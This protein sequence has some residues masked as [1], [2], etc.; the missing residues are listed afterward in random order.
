M[1]KTL[2]SKLIIRIIAVALAVLAVVGIAVPVMGSLGANASAAAFSA[3]T[4]MYINAD[5]YA[6]F[7]SG[8]TLYAYSY[9]ESGTYLGKSDITPEGELYTFT[10]LSGAATVEIIRE[11]TALMNNAPST[12]IAGTNR[13]VYFCNTSG[14][15]DVHAYAWYMNGATAVKSFGD[16]PGKAM[17]KVTGNYYYVDVPVTAEKIIFNNGLKSGA[18]QTDNITLSATQNL[19]T[20]NTNQ[21]TTFG[22]ESSVLIDI[23]ERPNS[24]ANTVYV[25]GSQS[26][27]WSKYASPLSAAMTTVYVYAPAWTKGYVTYD[28]GDPLTVVKELSAVT[29]TGVQSSAATGFY[30]AQVPVESTFMFRPKSDSSAGSTAKLEVPS[31]FTKPCYN[32]ATK[33]WSELGENTEIADYSVTNNFNQ[34]NI[35]GVKATYYDYLSDEEHTDG[36]LMNKQHGTGF[37]NSADDWYPFFKFNQAISKLAKSNSADW[38]YPLYFGNFCNTENAYATSSH[39]SGG[40]SNVTSSDNAYAFNYLANNSNA[41]KDSTASVQGLMKSSLVNGNLMVTDS[42]MAPYFNNQ[43]LAENGLAKIVTGDFPFVI[44][45]HGTYK[46]YS[47]N[48]ENAKDNVYFTWATKGTETYPVR[49]NYG[50]G[51]SYGISDGVKYF[52]NGG[53]SGK[54]I[55]PFNNVS[56]TKGVKTYSNENLNYGFGIRMDIDFRVPEGGVIPGTSDPILFEFEGDDDLWVYITDN[57]TGESKL[58]LDMGGAHAK[59]TGRINFATRT[60]TV[61]KAYE[62]SDSS[63]STPYVYFANN[64][65]WSKVYAYFYN[66]SG[67]VGSSW[68]GTEMTN[69]ESDNYKI[70]IPDGATKVIFNSGN[71]GSQTVGIDLAGTSGAYYPSG[72]SNEGVTVTEWSTPPSDAGIGTKATYKT[73]AKLDFSGFFDNTDDQ[74]TYT[75]SVFYMERGLIESNMKINFTMTPLDNDLTVKNEID[76]AD[77]NSGLQEAVLEAERFSYDVTDDGE[78]AANVSYTDGDGNTVEM[79]SNTFE[80]AHEGSAFF[81]AQFDTGSEMT[82]EEYSDTA[83]GIEY[84]TVWKLYDN[85]TGELIKE[86]TSL[87][88]LKSEFDLINASNDT[89]LKTSLYLAYVNTPKTDS[90]TVS[91]QVK[92]ENGADISQSSTAVFEYSIFVDVS[93]GDEF[94]TYA[95]DYDLY[96]K[97]GTKIATLTATDGRF[98][99]QA[100]QKAVF[101]GMPIGAKY[102]I[103]EYVKNGYELGGITG[104]TK[105]VKSGYTVSAEVAADNTVKYTN[106]YKPVSATL[107]AYKTLAGEAYTGNDFTFKLEG[108]AKTT[109]NGANTEDTSGICMEV[110]EA[111]AGVIGFAN[112]DDYSPFTYGEEG[113]YCYKLTEVNGGKSG[114]I[115][116]S[117][118][119]YAK[120]TV[121]ADSSGTLELSSPVYY[122]DSSFTQEISSSQ[123][124]FQNK[125]KPTE[126]ELKIVKTLDG[127][128]YSGTEFEFSAVGVSA[129]T[130]GAAVTVN[131][132]SQGEVVFKN[133]SS[134]QPFSFEKPGVY[135]YKLCEASDPDSTEYIFDTTVYYAQVTVTSDPDTA[136]LKAEVKYYS[137]EANTIEAQPIIANET[138]KCTVYIH[139]KNFNQTAYLKGAKFKLVAAVKDGENWVADPNSTFESTEVEVVEISGE[140]PAAVFLN[141]PQGDYIVVETKAPVGYELSTLSPYLEV[142]KTAENGGVV[143]FDFTDLENQPLPMS[144]ASG[145]AL[146]T[147]A[148]L[149]LIG[150]AVLCMLCGKKEQRLS[151]KRVNN[152]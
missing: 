110:N 137:D 4:K 9:S 11:N 83:T 101:N 32:V 115:Y 55:F 6:E 37:N 53:S 8:V 40:W 88:A 15:T 151:N 49:V 61:D 144:G 67:T 119:Y 17:T 21:W 77:L 34:T 73:N 148:A 29:D 76:P 2:K 127:E 57:E 128:N 25:T 108:L 97:D 48:S 66:S 147:A 123:V 150:A 79:T 41:L 129:N 68:P 117:T 12:P 87:T 27:K 98:S 90:V 36:W 52:M 152:N 74:K 16:W 84:E 5:E 33:Q 10:A 62:L 47:F 58:L 99:L 130:A 145:F 114:Y 118:V 81:D 63:S 95:L 112:T 113:V 70:K 65:S 71:N 116:D 122:S 45:D 135:T 69:Y 14:M 86:S 131:T 30:V 26:A 107:T 141:V 44:T 59:S 92:D 102:K 91:K 72:E 18:T 93:E 28:P 78:K 104:G 146:G 75:M 138:A 7:A 51:T 19:Y 82:V 39:S 20:Q 60:A 100:G 126:A 120:I 111:S 139:K 22:V 149:S 89:N 94:G 38:S 96:G 121:T 3:D 24:E 103:T 1:Q 42:L 56:G 35:L 80:L 143:E 23:N 106:I 109:L 132:A 13:R 142:R 136:E 31:G 105:S 124:V 64:Y 125:Y 46:E 140:N 134:A 43:W 54:G 50:A 85:N 133:T